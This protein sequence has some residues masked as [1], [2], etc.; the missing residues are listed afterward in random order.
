MLLLT[1]YPDRSVFRE[2]HNRGW[3]VVPCGVLY[4]GNAPKDANGDIDEN[5]LDDWYADQIAKAATNGYR[6]LMLDDERPVLTAAIGGDKDAIR[7]LSPPLRMA[8]AARIVCGYYIPG[9]AAMQFAAESGVRTWADASAA[10]MDAEM[11]VWIKCLA[12]VARQR[13]VF[14]TLYDHYEGLNPVE[15]ARNTQ[16]VALCRRTFGPRLAVYPVVC[17]HRKG[18][19]AQPVL[20]GDEWRRQQIDPAVLGGADGVMVWTAGMQ[21]AGVPTLRDDLTLMCSYLPRV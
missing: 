12:L 6:F 19:A 8:L 3:E 1:D 13:A 2:A 21:L 18:D 10:E 5:Q 17:H 9:T 20:S 11:L 7:K 14:P 15:T 4:P 16:S